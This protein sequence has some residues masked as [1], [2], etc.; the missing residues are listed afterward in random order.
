M[1]LYVICNAQASNTPAKVYECFDGEEGSNFTI[2]SQE[3][4]YSYENQQGYV[5]LGDVKHPPQQ[6]V[7]PSFPNH[8][9]S[10]YVSRTFGPS[11]VCLGQDSFSALA[12]WV[13]V[14]LISIQLCNITAIT[15]CLVGS[16]P[17][18]WLAKIG[19]CNNSDQEVEDPTPASSA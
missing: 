7:F 6:V 12:K 16:R 3:E 1:I 2:V 8:R 13:G 15:V 10:V 5:M 9:A 11:E 14:L 18:Q 19:T 17:W 4:E